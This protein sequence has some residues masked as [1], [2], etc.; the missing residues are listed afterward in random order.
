[1]KTFAKI[2]N[3]TV[4]EIIEADSAPH[5]SYIECKAGIRNIMPAPSYKY[6]ADLDIF[7]TPVLEDIN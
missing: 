2:E 4:I 5:E 3:N 1:M 6:D 7:Y